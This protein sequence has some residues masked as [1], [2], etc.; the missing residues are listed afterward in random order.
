MNN[1]DALPFLSGAGGYWQVIDEVRDLSVI[2]Q[3]DRLSCGPACA[4]MLLRSKG[5][6]NVSQARIALETGVPVSV[7]AKGDRPIPT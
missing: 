6:T 7:P 4:E 3:Q 2:Q 1:E 5:I